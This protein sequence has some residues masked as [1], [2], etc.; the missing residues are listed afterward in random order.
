[1]ALAGAYDGNLMEVARAGMG[2]LSALAPALDSNGPRA[3]SL[4]QRREFMLR[5]CIP[6]TE[7]H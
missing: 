5:R 7:V 4:S 1:M 2:L 3:R 6:R